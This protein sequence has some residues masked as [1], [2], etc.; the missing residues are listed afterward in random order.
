MPGVCGAAHVIEVISYPYAQEIVVEQE[1]HLPK[2][3]KE[4]TADAV[5][6]KYALSI[7]RGLLPR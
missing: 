1:T 6:S 4:G 2:Y 3:R 5:S 7:S